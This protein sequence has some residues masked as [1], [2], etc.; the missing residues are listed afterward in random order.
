MKSSQCPPAGESRQP[1]CSS[2][3]GSLDLLI[4]ALGPHEGSVT[5]SR[6]SRRRRSGPARPAQV[7]DRSAR[8]IPLRRHTDWSDRRGPGGALAQNDPAAIGAGDSRVVGELLSGNEQAF[9]SL[10]TRHHAAMVR[11]ATSLI[12]DQTVAERVVNNAWRRILAGLRTLE[13][14]IS[15]RCW[16]YQVVTR[17]ARERTMGTFTIRGSSSGGASRVGVSVR[18][19]GSIGA[20]EPILPGWI[21]RLAAPD[22]QV[23]LLSDIEGWN[24]L[25]VCQLLGLTDSARSLHLRR[26]RLT[27]RASFDVKPPRDRADDVAL[28]PRSIGERV[29]SSVPPRDRACR[30]VLQLFGG[31]RGQGATTLLGAGEP[32]GG[33][34]RRPVTVPGRR[35]HPMFKDI[36]PRTRTISRL[37]LGGPMPYPPEHRQRTRERIVRSA[38]VMF[39]R[40]GFD[41]VSIDQIM[42]HV[43]L[44]RGGFY[45]YFDKKSDLYA[46]AVGMALREVPVCRL[47][48]IAV[49]LA[50]PDAA[51]Q[52]IRAYLSREHQESVD[53]S[54]PMVTVPSD[55]ARS[56]MAVKLVFEK[57]FKALVDLFSMGLRRNGISSRQRALVVAGLCV[58]GMVIARGVADP[59]LADS[60]LGASMAFALKLGGWSKRSAQVAYRRTSGR[61]AVK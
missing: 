24:G 6:S 50:A 55:V 2:P 59:N 25:E 54:C 58:G 11:Y 43:G 7:T 23:L 10:V 8:V 18:R 48:G 57:V 16:M 4:G 45:K 53:V 3:L 37:I 29:S 42:A 61:Q 1:T 27:V 19:A 38:Q 40:H 52:A 56:D 26:A 28:G 22:R 33:D 14:P 47:S 17:C 44:T 5:R 31:E 41:A 9:L 20:P 34:D 39:N 60:V 32:R 51:R 12:G 35:P 30:G 49:D 36:F 15:L 13:A 21:A 46:E